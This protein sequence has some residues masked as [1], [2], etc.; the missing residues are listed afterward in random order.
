[1][2]NMHIY[3]VDACNHLKKDSLFTNKQRSRKCLIF[4]FVLIMQ[5]WDGVSQDSGLMTQC[6]YLDM[7][8]AKRSS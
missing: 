8:E 6:P 3:T 1:M 2:L 5:H 7:N 4:I